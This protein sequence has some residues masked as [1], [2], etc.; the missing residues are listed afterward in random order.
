MVFLANLAVC[1]ANHHVAF[2][3]GN[4]GMPSAAILHSVL[5]REPCQQQVV[6]VTSGHSVFP[7]PLCTKLCG[8]S[9][10][11]LPK[12]KPRPNLPNHFPCFF[13]FLFS[14]FNPCQGL[15]W[16]PT[17]WDTD[18]DPWHIS[19]RG[20]LPWWQTRGVDA[21]SRLRRNSSCAMASVKHKPQPSPTSIRCSRSGQEP[22]CW[23][24]AATYHVLLAAK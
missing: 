11:A 18:D 17:D 5:P 19:S 15:N 21:D 9:P 2:F 23:R 6:D 20:L 22:R 1:P 13:R 7:L 24:I 4:I 14:L 16:H 8:G 3:L 12:C 10:N